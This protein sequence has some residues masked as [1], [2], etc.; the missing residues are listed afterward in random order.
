V[1]DP[2]FGAEW[3]DAIEREKTALQANKTWEEV[4]PPY[5]ANIISSRWVFAIKYAENGGI[6]K[7]KARL[8]AR[9]F[10]QR[11]GIDYQDTFAPTMRMDSL[12]VLLALVAVEDLECH[13]VDVNNAFT[14]SVNTELIYMSAPDGI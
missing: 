10:S 8:V 3:L 4:M 6:E 11:Q 2:T 7:F 1:E 12:R 9:G 5:R 13:Q 14:E